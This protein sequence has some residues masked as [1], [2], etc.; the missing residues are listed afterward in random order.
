[1]IT[2]NKFWLIRLS[3][4]QCFLCIWSS[5]WYIIIY[6]SWIFLH[7]CIFH[8]YNCNMFFGRY[9]SFLFCSFECCDKLPICYKCDILWYFLKTIWLLK[10]G[11]IFEIS[12]TKSL[13]NRK[14]SCNVYRCI[15][16]ANFFPICSISNKIEINSGIRTFACKG[17]WIF[18]T[19]IFTFKKFIVG[20]NSFLMIQKLHHTLRIILR[21]VQLL[22][23]CSPLRDSIDQ[24]A[25]KCSRDPR[26]YWIS[27][28]QLHLRS[29]TL[30]C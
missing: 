7:L 25:V 22:Y 20:W 23:V 26:T 11:T 19:S 21:I 17:R 14:I 12:R 15:W 10:S 13:G 27:V 9:F 30:L 18:F 1:M 24:I 5:F 29:A 3:W 6:N 28:M 8:H 2:P 16:Y 4:F